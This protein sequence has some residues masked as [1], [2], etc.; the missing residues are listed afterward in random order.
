MKKQITNKA[1]TFGLK[2]MGILIVMLFISVQSWG[3]IAISVGNPVSQD[4]NS[5]GTSATATLPTGWKVDK[6]TVV[7]TLGTYTAA[8]S[9]TGVLGGN[10][11]STS[12]GNGIYNF[13]AGIAASATDRA[14]GGISSGTASKTVNIYA[15]LTN[16]GAIITD[17]TISY[18]VEKYR[19]GSNSSGFSIQMYYST[20]GAVWTSAGSNFLTSFAA[21]AD[22]TG[23]AS[24]PGVTTNVT[25]KTLSVSVAASAGLYLA[26]SYSVTS[27]STTSNAQALGIDDVL[28]TANGGAIV[29][30]VTTTAAS[31]IGTT[32]ATFNGNITSDGG[33]T[34][35]ERGFCYNTSAGV[36]IT[37]NKTAEGITAVGSYSKSFSLTPATNY[38]Y[39]AYATNSIGTT[40]SATEINFWTLSDEPVSHSTSF[41]NNVISQTQIDVNFDA[42]TSISNAS[43]YMILKKTASVPTGIPADA[44]AYSVG[45][46][47]GDATVAAIVTNTSATSASINGLSAGTNYYFTIIPFNNGLNSTT[48]NYKTDGIFPSTNGTTLLPLDATSEVSGPA[49]GSQPNPVL[50]SSLINNAVDAVRVFDMD[51]WDYATADAQPT[52]ITQVAIKAGPNNTAKWASTLQGVKLSTDAGTSFVTIGTPVITDST[53]VIP[54]AS[55]NLNILNGNAKTI[56][57]YVYLKNSGLTDNK[58]LEF[59]V[60]SAISSHGFT[61]DATGSTFL[62]TFATAPVSNQMLIDVVATKLKFVQQPTSVNINAT[63]SPA[64]TIEAT[65]ANNNRDLD[66]TGTVSLIS[67]GTMTGAVSATLAAGFGT[68]GGIVH[69][70]AGTGLSLTASLSQLSD[71]TSNTFIVTLVPLLTELVVPQY[72]GGR[73]AGTF[74]N[75]RTPIAVCLNIDNL[76]PNTAY[77][78]KLG[79]SLTSEAST[80]FGAGV[81]WIGSS[82]INTNI[83]NIFTTNSSGSSGIFW[84]YFEPSNNSTGGR[85]LPGSVHNLRIGYAVH[86]ATMSSAPNFVTTKTITCL[87]LGTTALTAGTTDDGAFVKGTTNV[88]ASGKYILTYDNVSG[89]GNPLYSY[90][91]RTATATNDN[92]TEIPTSVNDVFMQT[93]TSAIGDYASIIPIGA[94]NPNGVRRIEVRNADNSIYYYNTDADGIWAS[95][96]NTTTVLRRAVVNLTDYATISTPTPST[97]SGFTTSSGAESVEQTFTVD[98]SNLMSDLVITAPAN[99]EVRESGV[100]S[101]GSSVSFAPISGVVTTKTIE[102]RIAASAGVGSPSGNVVCNSTAAISKNIAVSGTVISATSPLITITGSLT[103]FANTQVNTFSLEQSYNV[104]GSNLTSDI[105]ITPPAGF[106]ISTTTGLAFVATNP[107][108]LTQ[109][110]GIVSPTTIYVRFAPLLVQ[111]YSGNITNVSTGA[112]QKDK[113]VSGLGVTAEPSNHATSFVA[114]AVSQVQIDLTFSAAS[115]ITNAAGYLILQKTGSAPS[116]APVDANAY[117]VGSTIG[118]ATVAANITNLADTSKAITGLAAGTHYY[119]TIFPYNWDGV[120][121]VTYNYKTDAVVPV[122]D[123]ITNLALDAN[124]EVSGPALLSQPNPVSISSLI[125]SDAAAIRVFDM[126]IYDYSGDAEP[127]KITQVT[128][129]AGTA[130]TANWANTIQGV[131]LST[132]GGTTFVT[133]GTP[134]ITASSIVF[135]ITS[136]N[137][138]VPDNTDPAFTISLYIY[139]KTSGLTDNSIFEFKVDNTA[140]SHGFTADATGSTFLPTFV[141]PTISHQ[142][143]IDVVATKLNFVQQP[144][145]VGTSVNI[146]PAVT[147]SATDANGNRDLNYATN[148]NI[149]AIGAT[150]NASPVSVAPINGLATFNTLSFPSAATSVTLDAVSGSLTGATSNS[151]DILLLPLPGEI[152]INQFSSD[153]NGSSNEYVELV[154]KTDKT[155]DLSLFKIEYKAASGGTGTAGGTLSGTLAPYQYWLLSPDATITVGQTT[156]LARDGA[157]TAG[158]A[159]A[160]GQLA[161]RLVNTPNTIIDGLAYG[162]IT[163]NVLGEGAAASAPPA[164]GGLLRA[165]DGADNNVN[166][167]DFTTVTQANIYLRNHNS[168]NISNTYTLPSTTYTADVVI[169]GTAPNVALSGNTTIAGKLTILTGNLTVASNQNLTVNGTLT[170]NAGITGLVIKSDGSG[171]AS[172]K[173]YT[174]GVNA[175]VE[176]FIP[177]MNADEFHML[178]SPVSGQAIAPNFNEPESFFVWNEPTGAW[179]ELADTTNFAAANFGSST[180]FIPAKGYAVSYPF[181]TLKDFAGV[182][183]EGNVTIPLTVTTGTYS[184]WNFVANPY[185]SAIDWSVAAGFTRSMLMP[186][187]TENAMWIWDA[188]AGQYGS[189]LSNGI[190]NLPSVTK[191]IAMGQGF[192]VLANTAGTFGINN[193]ARVHSTQNFLKSSTTEEMLRLAV[194]GNANSYH[195]GIVVRFGST[196]DQSGAPKMFSLEAS[197]P[198]LYSTKLNK[199][200]SINSLT[201]IAQHPVV[202]VSFKAGANGNYTITASELNSFAT[203]TYVYLKDL[204]TNTITNLNQNPNYTFA[205]TTN[206]NADRFQLIFAASPLGILDNQ[207]QN[208]S[209]YSNNNNIYINS[210]EVVKQ[211]SIYN[212]LGQLVKTIDS[213]NG[214][215]IVNMNGNVNGYYIVRVITNK[216]VY[217][218]KVLIK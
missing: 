15:Y 102:V 114:T 68:F 185:P 96:A 101:Y 136:G 181:Q 4:F 82:F 204:K 126:D 176:R 140:S 180:N 75:A 13:G 147:I 179:I 190:S 52:I 108:T 138:N 40:L 42:L 207:I 158:F 85:F 34:I 153:Y 115:T 51:I 168:Y 154:N 97:L 41:T 146:T 77:D 80:S 139:L 209:I 130:N 2:L 84:V 49:L 186:D 71:A 5:I 202:P 57:L 62:P 165:S 208:T 218:E 178:A 175:T 67:S 43:G 162:T 156:S 107:I 148:I 22:N 170:N 206:D 157:I 63:M 169:S 46:T 88:D 10:D 118:D 144:S 29:P 17:F 56:S 91:I 18:A 6:Q 128:I 215:I 213:N 74:N 109:I 149:M 37:D 45:N 212:T 123:A 116:G 12:A 89:T 20:D 66:K 11:M 38:F 143:L 65:D 76:L 117:I 99:F 192:W 193:T 164:D 171:T 210:N 79:M 121:V 142:I 197:A 83:A 103:T 92:Q 112:T 39:K 106:E 50:I 27:G 111:T 61:A 161:L 174:A 211:I 35:T 160:S 182:L 73:T 86:G 214:T 21:D 36:L 196:S 110:A 59:K 64:V 95:G 163:S 113:A 184:G 28:I 81:W 133:T 48:Y 105:I 33:S 200:W 69:T 25:N 203:T 216:N 191:D 159:A 198:S 47:I 195:D 127:T 55:G 173:H 120:N 129:K 100:G 172:L 201:T 9:A 26:W 16:S 24:A 189:C 122:T 187:G 58:I 205:A 31:A 217:S 188:A 124:S 23:Y 72:I 119:F 44:I 145:N 8:V 155:F 194:S 131:K 3:Q 60:N 94:N 166:A 87:D 32:T 151:F 1:R 177:H 78:L 152:V 141:T 125:T 167:T 70:V 14:V 132:D 93:G 199:N 150:L 135:P 183:N 7:R 98:G 53:I 134:V 30:S 104:E 137:L 19:K 54:I 90:Q